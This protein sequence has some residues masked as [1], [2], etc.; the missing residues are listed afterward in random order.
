MVIRAVSQ[1]MIAPTQAL[2]RMDDASL[3][4]TRMLALSAANMIPANCVMLEMCATE[5]ASAFRK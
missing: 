1:R 3:E 2:V 4:V 5:Q